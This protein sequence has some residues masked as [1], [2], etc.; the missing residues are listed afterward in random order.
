MSESEQARQSEYFACPIYGGVVAVTA[1]ATPVIV[2]M[3][4]MAGWPGKQTSGAEP[5][6][7]GG[8]DPNPLGHYLTLQ[9]DGADVYVVFGKT[10]ANLASISVTSDV[11]AV[12]TNSLANSYTATGV[13]IIPNK[14]Q[15]NYKIPVGSNPGN[16][17]TWAAN[18]PARYLCFLTAGSTCTLRMWQSSP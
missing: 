17:G 9:A 18:S 16:Q 2:D 4:T 13:T 1:S 8:A 12:N 6:V 11:T 3:T 15:A 14:Q 10:V 7:V 5:S